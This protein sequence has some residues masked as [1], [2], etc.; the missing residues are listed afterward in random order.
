MT[1]NLHSR[2]KLDG[3][4]FQAHKTAGAH[5]AQAFR[6]YCKAEGI[7]DSRFDA[8]MDKAVTRAEMA[9]YFAHVLEDAYYA[10]KASVSLRDIAAEEYGAD[11]LRLAKADIVT[12]YEIAGSDAREFRPANSVTRAEA[13]VFIRNTLNAIKEHAAQ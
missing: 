11:I 3:Y 9:Y 10:D 5:W 7:I 13:A 8:G 4:D 6:D 2:M 1:A 12:G